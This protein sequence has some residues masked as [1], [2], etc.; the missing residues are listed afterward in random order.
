MDG[1]FCVRTLVKDV[2]TKWREMMQ[3]KKPVPANKREVKNEKKAFANTEKTVKPVAKDTNKTRRKIV[4]PTKG[5]N[6]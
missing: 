4:K 2:L 5:G 6:K 1:K 3:A